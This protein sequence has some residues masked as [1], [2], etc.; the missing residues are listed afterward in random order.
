MQ[1]KFIH[2]RYFALYNDQ[3]EYRGTLVVS[4]YL[5]LLRALEGERRLL[6][7]RE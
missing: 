6:D 5:A 2:I 7:E 4:Q 3:G 1:D